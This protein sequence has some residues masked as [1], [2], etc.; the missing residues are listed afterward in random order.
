LTIQ[1]FNRELLKALRFFP[2][3]NKKLTKS[4]MRKAFTLIE[5]LIVIAVIGILSAIIIMSV[6]GTRGKANAT[7]AKA[8]MESIKN[9]VERAYSVEGCSTFDFTN[10]GAGNKA[11]LTCG[12]TSY[13]DIQLPPNGTYTL[14][15]GTCV[16]TGG[17]SW[18]KSGTCPT[19]AAS[20]TGAYTLTAANAGGTFSYACTQTGCG[21]TTASC[22]SN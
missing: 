14:T 20:F 1:K 2:K 5:M 10:A 9:A 6:S 3:N 15:V 7:R 21:C 16:N 22:D 17:T 12:G 4:K 11:T 13:T 8:D 19:T 18:T